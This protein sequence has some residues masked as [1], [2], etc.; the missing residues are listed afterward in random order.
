LAASEKTGWNPGPG[1]AETEEGSGESARENLL[2]RGEGVCD[3]TPHKSGDEYLE[4]T[5]DAHNRSW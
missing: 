5:R 2:I 4:S 3:F 1:L